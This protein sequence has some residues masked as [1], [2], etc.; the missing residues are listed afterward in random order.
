MPRDRGGVISFV[1]DGIPDMEVAKLL[2]AEGIAVRAGTHCAQPILA[3][4]GLQSTV[5]PSFAFYNT[6]TE[7]DVLVETLRRISLRRIS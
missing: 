6:R 3:R 7:V 2:D 4:F 1:M 5:R